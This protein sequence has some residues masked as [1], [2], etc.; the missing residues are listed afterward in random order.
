MRAFASGSTAMTGIEAVSNAVP[1]FRP[2]RW[3]NART[4]LTG[5]TGL[6][7]AMFAGIIATVHLR[8]VIP[9]AARTSCRNSPI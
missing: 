3:R 6:L 4:T 2:V 9:V 5:M 7:I 1:A 8:G